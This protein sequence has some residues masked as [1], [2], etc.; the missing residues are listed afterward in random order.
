MSDKTA[1]GIFQRY[2]DGAMVTN[3]IHG[4][5]GFL[6]DKPAAEKVA[7]ELYGDDGVVR[8]TNPDHFQMWGHGRGTQNFR[9]G[10]WEQK[11]F[12]TCRVGCET[13]GLFFGEH[14]HSTSDNNL[15]AKFP[16]GHVEGFS[17][18][19]LLHHITFED[20]NY[21]K[22]SGLS[23]NEVRKAGR[24][25][26]YINN[27]LCGTFSYREIEYALRHAQAL[28]DKLHDFPLQLWRQEDRAR[29]QGRKIFYRHHPASIQRVDWEMLE[30][31]IQADPA[32][33]P[34][35]AYQ[36]SSKEDWEID[37]EDGEW[38]RDT[39]FSTEI[40]WYR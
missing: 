11:I 29:V 38:V 12:E 20:S 25:N 9:T 31:S 15:Y 5:F 35:A 30:C 24:C 34:K 22:T 40:Y 1:W 4:P 19:R 10:E 28:L 7:K 14:P 36:Q 21:L 32:P 3:V 13:V 39:I 18:H 8:E 37:E 23:G 6:Y 26:I 33:F 16:D 17:G 27:L 2:R